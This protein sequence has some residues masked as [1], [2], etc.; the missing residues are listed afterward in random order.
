[1]GNQRKLDNPPNPQK[2]VFSTKLAVCVFGI[3]R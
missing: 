3:E 1:M 2:N